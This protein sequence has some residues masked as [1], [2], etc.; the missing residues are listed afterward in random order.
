MVS[1]AAGKGTGQ[2]NAGRCPVIRGILA[3]FAQRTTA[4]NGGIG[5]APLAFQV[6][7]F[8]A[9][10]TALPALACGRGI[11][12][13]GTGGATVAAAFRTCVIKAQR[14]AAQMESRFA[15]KGALTA[16]A[17]PCPV[18]RLSDGAIFTG[19]T[20]A[21]GHG[22]CRTGIAFGMI[23]AITADTALPAFAD[24]PA[25]IRHNTGFATVTAAFQRRIAETLLAALMIPG[26]TGVCASVIAA[27]AGGMLRR[28]SRAVHTGGTTAIN[29]GVGFA[30]ILHPMITAFTGKGAGVIHAQRLGMVRLRTGLA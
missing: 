5:Y 27:C 2:I 25:V 17:C 13:P 9:F 20:T 29:G 1:G 6:I 22:V 24:R 28:Y 16:K 21:G 10:K 12:R 19:I 11:L 30:Q 7:I 18:F 23:S 3:G 15:H 8:V 26:I 4:G 14:R